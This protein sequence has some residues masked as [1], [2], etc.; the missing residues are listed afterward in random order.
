MAHDDWRMQITQPGPLVSLHS[1]QYIIKRVEIINEII[2]GIDVID[3]VNIVS[4]GAHQHY[5]SISRLY[6][7]LS[8][9]SRWCLCWFTQAG[10]IKCGHDPVTIV[11]VPVPQ[12]C[13]PARD[14]LYL[15]KCNVT[16][17][18]GSGIINL[19]RQTHR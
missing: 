4:F 16:F 10:E 9:Q 2:D 11:R 1:W 14:K 7:L 12:Q 17:L 5:Q 13:D 6:I 18:L 15:Y 19:S 3:A 8:Q